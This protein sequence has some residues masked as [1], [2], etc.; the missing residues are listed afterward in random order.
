[1]YFNIVPKNAVFNASVS[2][3]KLYF[4]EEN[5]KQYPFIKVYNSVLPYGFR[6][7][8]QEI[9]L[10]LPEEL[11]PIKATSLEETK[12]LVDYQEKMKLVTPAFV[13]DIPY[14]RISP[15][16]KLVIFP[17]G[18]DEDLFSLTISRSLAKMYALSEILLNICKEENI[19]Y[20]TITKDS[21]PELLDEYGLSE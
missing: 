19:P 7:Y 14:K 16:S 11:Y 15:T 6:F 18:D 1:M 12:M 9:G 13:S 10:F 17:D 8:H 20:F 4:S 2:D 3:M 5:N 21:P